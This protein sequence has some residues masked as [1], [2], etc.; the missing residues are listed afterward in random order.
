MFDKQIDPMLEQSFSGLCWLQEMVNMCVSPTATGQHP[1]HCP[2]QGRRC[3]PWVQLGRRSRFRKQVDYG[4]RLVMA[5]PA[6]QLW[7]QTC[8]EGAVCQEAEGCTYHA[9]DQESGQDFKG[10]P[11]GPV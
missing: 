4:K 5:Q 7:G 1:R 10:E 11:P 9:T 2:A 6:G 3:R 8:W